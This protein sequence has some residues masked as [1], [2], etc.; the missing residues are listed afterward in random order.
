MKFHVTLRAALLFF[1][2]CLPAGAADWPQF[3]GPGGLGHAGDTKLP[4]AWSASQN[5]AWRSELP[6]HGASSPIVVGGKIFL[7]CY[8]GYGLDA[9]NPGNM[10]QLKLHVLCLERAS[11][12]PLW[13]KEIKPDLPE[14]GFQGSFITLHGYASST[15]VS[16][17][18]SL[19][20]FLGKSGV[21]AFDLD[22]KQ[23]WKTSVGTR[24]HGWGSGT[25]PVLAKDLVIVNASVESGSLVALNKSD[26]KTAWTARGMNSSWNTPL[27]VE[28]P[29]GKTEVVV[30]VQGRLLAFE[31][32]TGAALWNCTA[33]QD[34]VCPSV[35]AHDGV[36]YVIGGRSN[37]ALAVKAG[38]KGDVTSQ[39]LWKINKGSN[40]SSPVYHD[41]HLYWSSE[42]R[43]VVY[44]V[45][46]DKGT[47]VYEE[48][49]T[50]NPGLMYASPV[51]ADGKLYY[52]S[53]SNGTY[54]CDANPKFKLLSNNKL[55]GDAG[56]FNAS[57]VIHDGQ[58]LLRSNRYLYC[59]GRKN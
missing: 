58:V 59:I 5:V 37:T 52:V 45:N 48:R 44:C 35:V 53:R 33:I 28:L 1:G 23:L 3:R 31:P 18:S 57:A 12:K 34:Y 9:K 21:L 6:G 38:G 30:S 4:T 8:S 13:A 47:V 2:L 24:T 26:G 36:V 15:P 50:P 54:V 46:V 39:V 25:S 40:V 41:G 49:L 10:E 22:G 43:G 42:G 17:G 14:Q 32:A 51:V 20:V 56:M 7:T 55:D 16:D 11:G 29:G 27:L 19:F